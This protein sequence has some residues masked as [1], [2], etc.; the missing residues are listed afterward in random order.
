MVVVL[1]PGLVLVF[2]VV[3]LILVVVLVCTMRQ[4]GIFS[5]SKKG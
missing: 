1:V 3:V 5:N 2:L 4:Y